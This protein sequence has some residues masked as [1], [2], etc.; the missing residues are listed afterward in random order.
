MAFSLL[1][2][3]KKITLTVIQHYFHN[4]AF[5]LGKVLYRRIVGQTAVTLQ[6]S[7]VL[8]KHVE[9]DEFGQFVVGVRRI[10]HTGFLTL[11]LGHRETSVLLVQHF[12]GRLLQYGIDAGRRFLAVGHD[13]FE[14][15]HTTGAPT[16]IAGIRG[17]TIR[18]RGI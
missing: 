7:F 6:V 2:K 16:I 12:F 4:M 10:V 1:K 3:K 17:Q 15:L 13:R 8:D 9:I 11:A 5:A 18:V 14:F